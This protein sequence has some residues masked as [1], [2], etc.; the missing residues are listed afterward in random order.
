MMAKQKVHPNPVSQLP[1]TSGIID[2]VLFNQVH[3]LILTTGKV[4]E[5]GYFLQAEKKRIYAGP[6][7]GKGNAALLTIDVASLIARVYG[8]R[9]LQD[10]M[11][12][13]MEPCLYRNT[14]MFLGCRVPEEFQDEMLEEILCECS[15]L[16]DEKKREIAF[17][18]RD[19]IGPETIREMF[20]RA[21]RVE[22]RRVA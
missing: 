20:L 10:D 5:D 21:L 3:D 17:R 6:K 15:Y 12:E 1:P 22:G 19:E 11:S 4:D 2:A 8:C 7:L 16:P 18:A 14:L 13:C 9:G